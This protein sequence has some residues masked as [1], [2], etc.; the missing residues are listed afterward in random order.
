MLIDDLRFALPFGIFDHRVLSRIAS[1]S[2]LPCRRVATAAWYST[3]VFYQNRFLRRAGYVSIQSMGVDFLKTQAETRWLAVFRRIS[4]LRKAT[5]VRFISF[6]QA[7][8][9][10]NR[11]SSGCWLPM[12]G[13]WA[14]RIFYRCKISSP[15]HQRATQHRLKQVLSD[16][17]RRHYDL[18]RQTSYT[19]TPPPVCGRR[20]PGHTCTA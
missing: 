17:D 19:G 7:S 5:F 1:R 13:R 16:R 2:D 4:R 3:A 9:A 11:S 6:L 10:T 12:R 18:A 20:P 14:R 15:I 8:W